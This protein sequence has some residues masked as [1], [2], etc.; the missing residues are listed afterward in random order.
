[1]PN[2]KT[3]RVKF[4][5]MKKYHLFCEFAHPQI[6]CLEDAPVKLVVALRQHCDSLLPKVAEHLEM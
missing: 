6:E 3:Q 2:A 4:L 5:Y 1:M